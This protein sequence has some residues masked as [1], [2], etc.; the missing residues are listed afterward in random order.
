MTEIAAAVARL[1]AQEQELRPA[2]TWLDK[3]P[4]PNGAKE[5]KRKALAAMLRNVELRRL[6]LRQERL[7]FNSK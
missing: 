3:A 4:L 6:A 2:L 7:P 1:R 5:R